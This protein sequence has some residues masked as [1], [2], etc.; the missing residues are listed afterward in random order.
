MFRNRSSGSIS[1]TRQNDVQ[2]RPNYTGYENEKY[3]DLDIAANHTNKIFKLERS[4]QDI[5]YF[6][7]SDR[8]RVQVIQ[9]FL[10]EINHKIK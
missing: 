8:R 9:L 10:R 4:N 2:H 6:T 7:D 3:L 5:Y 1:P